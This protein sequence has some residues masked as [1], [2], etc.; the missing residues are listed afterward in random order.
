MYRLLDKTP[1]KILCWTDEVD[2][3]AHQSWHHPN[4]ASNKIKKYQTSQTFHN[5]SRI[6]WSFC[7]FQQ[8][9]EWLGWT[10]HWPKLLQISPVVFGS[11]GVY[12]A[13]GNSLP[14]CRMVQS[15]LSTCSICTKS[16]QWLVLENKTCGKLSQKNKILYAKSV[17]NNSFLQS[18]LGVIQIVGSQEFSPC[19]VSKLAS[20]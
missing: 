20:R 5:P 18:N 19:F 16:N 11:W 17:I 6:F 2:C 7:Q 12:S 13:R 3:E 14:R 15:E 1:A 8:Q 9:G 4:N 10:K